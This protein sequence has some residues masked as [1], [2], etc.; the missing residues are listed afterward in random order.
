[1]PIGTLVSH[2]EARIN[3]TSKSIYSGFDENNMNEEEN[4]KNYL[5]RRINTRLNSITN[6]WFYNYRT[7]L[8]NILQS[9]CVGLN[10]KRPHRA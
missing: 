6:S 1:M 2:E 7:A 10:S 8:L 9:D 3:N 5:K 4:N